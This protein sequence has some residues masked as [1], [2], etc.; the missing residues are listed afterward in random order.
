MIC[1]YMVFLGALAR[2]HLPQKS[3]VPAQTRLRGRAPPRKPAFLLTV[4]TGTRM[5][6]S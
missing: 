1:K 3:E 4:V 2:L 6:F 5:S